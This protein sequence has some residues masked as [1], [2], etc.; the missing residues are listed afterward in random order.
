MF[1]D[2]SKGPL[3]PFAR[4][5][6]GLLGTPEQLLERAY[7]AALRIELIEKRYF[8]GY[9][10]LDHG[11]V[12]FPQA[13]FQQNL[14]ML[15]RS[16]R[17]F[18]ANRASL[19][20]LGQEQLTKVIFAEGILSKYVEEQPSSSI[21]PA[22]PP[23]APPGAS[24]NPKNQNSISIIDVR[25]VPGE[26]IMR[27]PNMPGPKKN[28][29]LQISV[30]SEN[31]GQGQGVL[32][33]SLQRTFGKLKNEL[34]PEAEEEVINEFRRSR[35]QTVVALRLLALII[36]VPLIT[37]Q[38]TKNFLFYPIISQMRGADA[39]TFINA[40]MKEEAFAELN[41]FEEELKLQS[42]ISS[43]PE[44]EP[45]AMEQ[46]V[47]EKAL[48]LDEEFRRKS[49]KA[50]SNVFA[51]MVALAGFIFTLLL[52]RGDIAV[53][54]S[55][56]DTLVSGLSDSA[57]AFAIILTTD[58]SVGFHSPHGWDVLLESM[59]THLGIAPN[60]SLISLF[61]ATVP[62]VADTM[63]KYWIFRSLSRMSPSTVATL[64]EMDD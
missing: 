50:I 19:G 43:A 60:P 52:R 36:V 6:D 53:L 30:R 13:E 38:V 63:V 55:F 59:A 24:N 11:Q 21:V 49:N 48:E 45:E 29:P 42:F 34:N 32:P 57:K 22:P 61:I 56:I 9:K 4:I 54:K 62:V 3:N 39:P 47:K 5:K 1:S 28:A 18:N 26:Q 10:V 51:D 15:E 44:F 37:Q 31:E 41:T 23:I 35:A 58:L 27:R 8:N 20:K 2:S 12:N 7:E 14:D 40:E 25:S 64:K 46:Q 17:G 33:K 16:M